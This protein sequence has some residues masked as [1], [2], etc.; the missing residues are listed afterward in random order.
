V[1]QFSFDFGDPFFDVGGYQLG[2]QIVTFENTYGLDP[3][4]TQL[5]AESPGW[6]IE[7]EGLTAA[8]G[9]EERSG[10]AWLSASPTQDGLEIVASAELSQKIRCLKLLVRSLPT[11]DLVGGRWETEPPPLV[12]KVLRYPYD[13]QGTLGLHTPLAFLEH[14]EA[15]FTYLQS[16]DPRVRCKRFA[17]HPHNGGLAAELIHE[18][19]AHEM[20]TSVTTPSWRVGRCTDPERVVEEHLVQLE[21]AHGL[22]PWESRSDVPAWAREIALVVAIHGMHWTGHIFNTYA[23][24]LRTLEWFCDRIEGR[25]LLAFLPGWEGRYYW[26]YGDYRPEPLLGGVDGFRELTQGAERLGVA[27][28]PMFGAH[29][30]NTG[31]P[32]FEQWGEPSF[33]RSASGMVFQGNKPD[34]D[35]SRANDPG[36]QAWLNPGAPA[37][38]ERLLR[39]VGDLVADYRL[40][41][42]FFDTHFMWEN[43][44]NFPVYE[45][46]VALRNG[47][48]E[49]FPDLLI[50]GEG[51][52]DALGAVTPVSQSG[53]TRRWP[54][55][56]SRYCRT[57]GHLMTGDPSCGSTGVHEAGTTGFFLV[58]E[59][60]HFWPTVTIVGETLER[61]PEKV[62]Q[63]IEQARGY[64]RRYLS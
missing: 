46:L 45:G 30:A 36:W 33:L 49:R 52:Y 57:F 34:W 31:L 3:S 21:Q 53:D 62:E 14:S 56:F 7:S 26:Q 50:A 37:W 59:G 27:L 47:L 39:Q 19:A 13:P 42:V 44:P 9:Q 18:E 38:R 22:R 58:P 63:V 41:A 2:L 35:A 15:G 24:A 17:I 28:M 6:R 60:R 32:G 20:G 40:P 55:I 48:H 25:R 4:K 43:D 10:R 11:G 54:Q 23:D 1:H 64:V 16:L 12:G 61:A 8:G 29:C 5:R 51:W